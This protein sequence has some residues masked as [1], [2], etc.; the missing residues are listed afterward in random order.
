MSAMQRLAWSR[1]RP[2]LRSAR[3]GAHQFLW[4]SRW[5]DHE[6]I[7]WTSRRSITR[8]SSPRNTSGADLIGRAVLVGHNLTHSAPTPA[9]AR[10][11]RNPALGAAAGDLHVKSPER[12]SLRPPAR[13]RLNQQR[14]IRRRGQGRSQIQ[15]LAN[16]LVAHAAA[17]DA[18]TMR[19][20]WFGPELRPETAQARGVNAKVVRA[21]SRSPTTTECEQR[22]SGTLPSRPGACKR[23]APREPSTAGSRSLD[24]Q[25]TL[26]STTGANSGVAH[27]HA[28]NT[29]N[30]VQGA[31]SCVERLPRARAGAATSDHCLRSSGLSRR[32]VASRA[33]DAS[34]RH[35]STASNVRP[36]QVEAISHRAVSPHLAECL[37]DFNFANQLPIGATPRHRSTSTWSSVYLMVLKALLVGEEEEV[38]LLLEYDFT[39]PYFLLLALIQLRAVLLKIEFSDV[40]AAITTRLSLADGVPLLLLS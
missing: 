21:L 11:I 38:M 5:A 17:G 10:S 24:E 32:S 14:A 16:L 29:R 4:C 33:S 18:P 23:A 40:A 20:T 6:S 28:T 2:Q 37:L 30:K 15:K 9:S 36:V 22:L 34:R 7:S 26:P 27:A 8:T 39:A 3:L 13:A 19:L 35:T 12:D 1:R 31:S 25:R